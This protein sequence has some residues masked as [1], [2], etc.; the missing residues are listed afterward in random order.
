MKTFTRFT[1]TTL[2]LI[3]ALV[4]A[5]PVMAVEDIQTKNIASKQATSA[6]TAAVSTGLRTLKSVFITGQVAAGTFTNYSGVVTIEEAPAAGGPFVTAKDDAGNACV[7]TH[8]NTVFNINSRA[9][10]IRAV[11]AKTTEAALKH[12]TVILH[13]AK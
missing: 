10:Y 11:I 7:A 6:T 1:F 4:V 12:L 3:I 9:T 2:L 5:V 8:T 13:Y